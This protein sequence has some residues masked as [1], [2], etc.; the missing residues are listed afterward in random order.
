MTAPFVLAGGIGSPYSIKLRAVMRYRR[1]PHIWQTTLAQTQ[2]ALAQVPVP[3]I[4]VLIDPEGQAR[5]DSTPVIFDLERRFTARSVL[6]SDPA[7]AFLAC[8]IEDMAD[9]WGTKIMFWYRW[10]NLIDQEL[11]SRWLAADMQPAAGAEAMA[12]FGAAFRDR[13]ISRMPMVGCTLQNAPLIEATYRQLLDAFETHITA[14]PYL[15]GSCPSLADFAWAGQLYQ[16]AS[17]PTPAALMQARAP[18]TCRWVQ[19]IDDASGV[20]GQWR[21][22]AAALPPGIVALLALAGSVY[23]PFL[24]ANAA[25]LAKGASEIDVMLQGHRYRQ[26]PFKYQAKCLTALRQRYAALTANERARLDP[27][28]DEAGCLMPLQS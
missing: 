21:D 8:L 28:L 23:L 5:N 11:V 1:I 9:E 4:P 17:D 22:P 15:F 25:A 16:L 2:A 27:W 14:E 13:Q 6:P 10:A 12:A 24:V 18:F 7:Q 3:V 19:Q 26:A 20:D